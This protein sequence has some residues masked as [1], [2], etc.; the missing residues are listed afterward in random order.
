MRLT[1]IVDKQIPHMKEKL[2]ISYS[3][4]CQS[5]DISSWNCFWCNKVEDKLQVTDFF[6]EK[7]SAT[8]GYMGQNSKHSF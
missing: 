7:E 4:Y 5:K 8:F 6:T 2:L 3:T 1:K